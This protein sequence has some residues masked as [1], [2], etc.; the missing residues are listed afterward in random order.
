MNHSSIR[1]GI[2]YTAVLTLAALPAVGC[3]NVLFTAAYLLKGTDVDPDFKELKNKKVAVVC[4]PA[5]SLMYSSSNVGRE[6]AMQVSNLLEHKVPK[7]KMIDQR[8]IARWAD[9]N[10]WED[11]VEVGK[12]MKADMVVAIDLESFST[13]KGQTLYQG[14]ANA[15]VRVYDCQKTGNK[16]VFKKH[17]PTCVYPPN[18]AVPTSERTEPEFSRQFIIILAERIGRYFYAHDPHADMAL[19]AQALK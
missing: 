19:D 8:K 2:L 16:E 4:R 11:Y 6:L 3:T 7:I 10:Q 12:A 18:M 14:N 9:E 17:L 15:T 5:E 13:Y 1:R